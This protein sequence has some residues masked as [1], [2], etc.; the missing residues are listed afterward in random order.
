M[1]AILVYLLLIITA[2]P[3]YSQPQL[4]KQLSGNINPEELITLSE[5]I[6]FDQ[7]IGVMSGISERLTGKKIVSSF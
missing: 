3:A 6:P 7:A 5:N 1:K 4:E 2:I